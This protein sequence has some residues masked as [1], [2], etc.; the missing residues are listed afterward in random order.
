MKK[1]GFPNI[2]GVLELK[3]SDER[4]DDGPIKKL[5]KAEDEMIEMAVT[6][7][8]ALGYTTNEMHI[9][10]DML[11]HTTT[12]VVDSVEVFR[13]SLHSSMEGYAKLRE[14]VK[15]ELRLDGDWLIEPGEMR[16]MMR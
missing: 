10:R 2:L 15:L 9:Y 16:R 7:F 6:T 11:R 8:I 4:F 5:I 13:V 14:P 1:S 12:L 3:P